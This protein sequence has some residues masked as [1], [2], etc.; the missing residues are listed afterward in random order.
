[1]AKKWLRFHALF[2]N[3]LKINLSKNCP[4]PRPAGV[5][6]MKH[7]SHSDALNVSLGA[8]GTFTK[9]LNPVIFSK[10]DTDIM[11]RA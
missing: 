6:P 10:S 1:M 8:L 5:V 2:Y 11:S 9:Y 4:W 7:Y 3:S